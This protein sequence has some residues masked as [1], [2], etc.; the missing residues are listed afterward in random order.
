MKLTLWQAGAQQCCARTRNGEAVLR[1][2]GEQLE[3]DEGD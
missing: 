1:F 2:A 3:A